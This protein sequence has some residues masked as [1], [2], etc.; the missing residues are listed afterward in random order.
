MAVSLEYYCVAKRLEPVGCWLW[1]VVCYVQETDW[2]FTVGAFF[3][4]SENL[5]LRRLNVT[6]N[7]EFSNCRICFITFWTGK[8]HPFAKHYFF[9]C[10]FVDLGL[11]KSKVDVLPRFCI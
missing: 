6:L 10:I 4:W 5:P 3:W 11:L 9:C 1:I 8:N 2:G 7:L